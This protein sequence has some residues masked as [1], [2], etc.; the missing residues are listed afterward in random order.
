MPSPKDTMVY[1]KDVARREAY[2]PVEEADNEQRIKKENIR[3]WPGGAAVKFAHFCFGSLGFAG[4]DP[5][6][7]LGIAA[8]AMLWQASH[9]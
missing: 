8:Q 7:D 3:G 9:I 1:E 6:M 4:L 2:N 5:G